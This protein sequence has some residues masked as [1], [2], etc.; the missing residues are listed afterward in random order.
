MLRMRRRLLVVSGRPRQLPSM[1]VASFRVFRE[2]S[3]ARVGAIAARP[4]QFPGVPKDIASTWDLAVGDAT[5]ITNSAGL[6]L[7]LVPG[8][9][10]TCLVWRDLPP[11]FGGGGGDCVPN[12]MALAGE[13][14]PISGGPAGVT[15]IG[16][17][18]NGNPTVRLALADGS[19]ES[20]PVSQ[21]VYLARSPHGFKTVTV[22]NSTGTVTTHGVPDG[23]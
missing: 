10:G 6:D 15:V 17:A 12:G 20:V 22:K 4:G 21:N 14:S 16:L 2:A 8:S 1:L 7:W 9:A 18:P 13:L 3:N 11:Q 23:G 19:S 5:Q